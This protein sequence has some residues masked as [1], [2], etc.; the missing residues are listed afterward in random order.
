MCVP[1]SNYS[2]LSSFF[3]PFKM[4]TSVQTIPSFSAYYA[5]KRAMR[6]AM[7]LAASSESTKECSSCKG[8]C[9]MKVSVTTIG[10]EGRSN[11]ESVLPCITC[12]GTGSVSPV[13]EFYEKLV[14]CNCKHKNETSFLCARDGVRV[15]GNTTYLCGHCG[16]VKQFG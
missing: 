16:F 5:H 6:T 8:T 13:K 3:L 1:C 11:S 7:R 10:V 4:S 12:R 2:L 15:F 9:E 14:W